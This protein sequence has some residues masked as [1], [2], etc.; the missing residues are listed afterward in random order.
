VVP[1][2]LLTAA[3]SYGA[4]QVV[5]TRGDD[6]LVG[7]SDRDSLVG[8]RGDDVL[9]ARAGND[10]LDGGAGR[11]RLSGGRGRD[12]LADF[13]GGD[14]LD[15]GTGND[16]AVLGGGRG[17]V[18]HLQ[19]GPGDDE[20]VVQDDGT[21]DVVGCGPGHDVAEWV[22]HRD[23]ADRYVGCEVVREYLGP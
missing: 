11:D 17:G 6:H 13:D 3:P 5:G 15:G 12:F 2:L 19:L 10:D 14:A 7:T 16:R 9:V 4:N 1:I 23:P 20:V 22:D 18:T 8:R 21:A